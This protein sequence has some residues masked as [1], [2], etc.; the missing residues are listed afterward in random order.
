MTEKDTT[1]SQ[2]NTA[3]DAAI[4][5]LRSDR[6]AI[7]SDMKMKIAGMSAESSK[8]KQLFQSRLGSVRFVTDVTSV[9]FY[10]VINVFFC[11]VTNSFPV[12]SLT[13]SL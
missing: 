13:L 1:L 11:D 12:T 7:V 8:L 3:R 6:D 10:D 9:C 2:T 4:E 5:N